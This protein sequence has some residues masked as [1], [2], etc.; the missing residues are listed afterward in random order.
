MKLMSMLMFIRGMSHRCTFS[1][2]FAVFESILCASKFSLLQDPSGRRR[3]CIFGCQGSINSEINGSKGHSKCYF[4]L[5]FYS[6]I[7]HHDGIITQ[8]TLIH[9]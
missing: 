1:P 3:C 8:V 5:Q 4:L 7:G 9:E 2:H 6:L